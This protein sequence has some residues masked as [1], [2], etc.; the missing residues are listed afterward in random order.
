MAGGWACCWWTST[1][2]ASPISTWPTTPRTISCTSTAAPAASCGCD[3]KGLF[4][5]VARDG[6]GAST[7]SMGVDAADCDRA[8]RPSLWVTN[9]ENEFHSLYRNDC[10]DGREMFAYYS[11][12]AGITAIGQDHVGWGTGF[13]DVDHHGW[14]DL[15]VAHGHTLR[16]PLEDVHRQ[17]RPVLSQRAAAASATSASQAGPYFQ[18]PH[19]GRGAALGDLDNDGRIDLVISH[20]NEP[21]VV[22][23]NVADAG[24]HWLGV[25][26]AG[27]PR[28][29]WS[30]PG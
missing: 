21:A 7:G 20:L 9:Y 28:R 16:Y 6:N 3:E 5:S 8:G 19:N 24:Q 25:E 14:E 13:L 11:G 2:T 29:T 18:E 15:F 10:K 30:A 23:R 26:L 22:L 4:L 17:Q 27:P 12:P 1:A